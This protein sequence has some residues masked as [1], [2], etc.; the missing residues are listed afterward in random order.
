MRHLTPP[1]PLTPER[2][3]TTLLAITP[4][5]GMDVRRLIDARNGVIEDMRDAKVL[6]LAKKN[7]TLQLA[8]GRE[9]DKVD[10]LEK[11]LGSIGL[12]LESGADGGNFAAPTPV[13]GSGPR[14]VRAVNAQ[15]LN[16]KGAH[17]FASPKESMNSLHTAP[18]DVDQ[19]MQVRSLT[20]QLQKIMRQA[21]L[22][23][24]EVIACH[25]ALQKEVGP[26][27]PLSRIL[28]A[29]AVPNR[30]N[31][32]E[33]EEP[34][35]GRSEV[36]GVDCGIAFSSGDW[37]GRAQSIAVLRSR[38][39]ALER[40]LD[41]RNERT[42]DYEVLQHSGVSAAH[43]APSTMLVNYNAGSGAAANNALSDSE[44][45]SLSDFSSSILPF[46]PRTGGPPDA[47][48][49]LGLDDASFVY[50]RG[51]GLPPPVARFVPRTSAG[52]AAMPVGALVDDRA[53]ASLAV[54]AEAKSAK[55]VALQTELAAALTTMERTRIESSA[56]SARCAVLENDVKRSKA[57]ARTLLV[58]SGADDHLIDRLRSELATTQADRSTLTSS[59]HVAERNAKG[60]S[61]TARA[62]TEAER[63]LQ[64]QRVTIN[65]LKEHIAVLRGTNAGQ[66]QRPPP[67][68]V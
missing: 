64:Q 29:H 24:L 54:K 3:E 46:D 40:D 56:K 65:S 17:A 15:S 43:A 6:D 55:V 44:N 28:I 33:A 49:G 36:G 34:N 47:A 32:A 50:K 67:M 35:F 10:R 53:V 39:R 59:L 52:V 63:I 61:D 68:P 51:G 9:K 11:K 14:A 13:A 38:V 19:R 12:G 16:I 4:V 48:F 5:P 37:R 27:V 30:S 21:D 8:I 66:T 7:R 42:T 23:R 25:K 62:L 22:M 31:A 45:Q 57:A 20:T 26:E 18:S 1:P 58:K 41:A 60:D 2:L